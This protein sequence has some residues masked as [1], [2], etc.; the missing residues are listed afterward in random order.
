MNNISIR[1][2]YLYLFAL[3]G[4]VIST[5]GAVQLVNLGL[6]TFVFSQAD[7]YY[8]YPAAKPVVAPDS[9][10]TFQEPSQAELDKFNA[11]QRA[12]QRQRDAANALAMLIVG[13]P[14]YAYHWKVIKKEQG[15]NA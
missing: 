6:K 2:I 10:T 7:T 3:I 8:N 9:T 5:I 14:L 1:K 12:S 4:L 15:T 11:Q 13:V